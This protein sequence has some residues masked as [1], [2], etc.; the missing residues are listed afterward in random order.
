MGR[1]ARILLLAMVLMMLPS[2]RWIGHMA[3]PILVVAILLLIF[4]ILPGVPRSIVPVR[5]GSTAWINL[6]FMLAQ[7]SEFA[8]LIAVLFMAYMLARK[9][10]RVNE[11]W[12]VPAPCL[13]IVGVMAFLILI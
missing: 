13:G 8:K 6:G 7:P 3:Y 12:T 1:G 9:E 4:V 10:E 5:N 2:P 11:F